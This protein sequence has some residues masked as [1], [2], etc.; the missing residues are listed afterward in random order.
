M[1]N[2]KECIF[3]FEAL[4][5]VNTTNTITDTDIDT[6]THTT[7]T[8]TDTDTKNTILYDLDT[9]INEYQHKLL[10]ILNNTLIMNCYHEFHYGCFLKYI[11]VKYYNM[12]VFL[13]SPEHNNF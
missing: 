6:N 12:F 11:K 13:S 4:N 1:F 9:R 10:C 7:N 8:I 2:Q 5:Y 3:C